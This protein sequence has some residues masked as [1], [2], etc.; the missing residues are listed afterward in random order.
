VAP[1][2]D[3]APEEL[4]PP[5]DPLLPVPP[6]LELVPPLEVPPLEVA[7]LELPPLPPLLEA[8]P[9]SVVHRP[10]GTARFV[11]QP[12]ARSTTKGATLRSVG[13]RRREQQELNKVIRILT[14]GRRAS[15]LFGVFA[16]APA[17]LMRSGCL[18]RAV[19]G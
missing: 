15:T 11:P 5:C 4:L 16:G 7:P 6:L 13:V 2:L 9:P 18:D 19:R 8:Q 12:A 17:S 3:V 14:S 1:L 10:L